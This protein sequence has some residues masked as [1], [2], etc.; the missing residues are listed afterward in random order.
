MNPA[1]KVTLCAFLLS[2]SAVSSTAQETQGLVRFD[3]IDANADDLITPDEMT[4]WRTGKFI[5]RDLDGNGII[6]RQE[7]M[8]KAADGARAM[9]W[10][11]TADFFLAYDSDGNLEV[12]HEEVVDAIEGSG[13]FEMIDYNGT[14]SITRYEAEGWLDVTRS[15]SEAPVSPGAPVEEIAPIDAPSW[16]QTGAITGSGAL[17]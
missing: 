6:T 17:Y 13:F 8:E 12:S 7:L 15:Q 2:V 4:E 11:E 3:T 16:P 9:E 1:F 14:G 5:T 10:D